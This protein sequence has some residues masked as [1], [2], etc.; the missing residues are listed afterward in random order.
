M[1]PTA[2][3]IGRLGSLLSQLGMAP[4]V[5]QQQQQQQRRRRRPLQRVLAWGRPTRPINLPNGEQ[6]EYWDPPFTT[7]P[8]LQGT[9]GMVSSYE[10]LASAAGMRI[11]ELGGN[12]FDAAIATGTCLWHTEPGMLSPGGEVPIVYFAVCFSTLSPKAVYST[13]LWHQFDDDFASLLLVVCRQPRR[14]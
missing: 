11:L 10:A 13:C 14:S 7:R 1:P 4:A 2:A 8:E 5:H 3:S 6:F 12:A 9:F